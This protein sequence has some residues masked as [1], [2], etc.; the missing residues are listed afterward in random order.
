MFL[1]VIGLCFKALFRDEKST[2]ACLQALVGSRVT[3]SL[4]TKFDFVSR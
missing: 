1:D 3:Y 2:S 4:L